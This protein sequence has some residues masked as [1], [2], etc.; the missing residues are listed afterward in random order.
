[1]AYGSTE[2]NYFKA[3]DNNPQGVPTTTNFSVT[4]EDN[5]QGAR[6]GLITIYADNGKRLVGTI[7]RGEKFIP[8]PNATDPSNEL[9]A[10]FNYFSDN[11]NI[12]EVKNQAI[13]TIQRSLSK[14]DP[15][16]TTPTQRATI[17]RSVVFG[18]QPGA[19]PDGTVVSPASSGGGNGGGDGAS[20]DETI[21]LN[22]LKIE[23][24]FPDSENQNKWWYGKDPFVYPDKIDKNNQDFIKFE[25]FEYITKKGSEENPLL[26]AER[27][28]KDKKATI[29]LPI[30]PTITDNNVVDWTSNNLNPV[31][32]GL[33]GIASAGMKADG[34]LTEILGSMGNTVTQD[35]NVGKALLLYLKQKAIGTTGLVSRFGG[36]V[37]NPNM[38]LLFQ[39]PQ[40]RPFNFSFRL[41][42]R[43]DEEAKKVKN[44]IRIFKESMSVR[45]S[46]QGLFLAAPHIFGIKYINGSTKKDHTSLNRIKTCALQSCSVDY[47]PDGSYMTFNDPTTGFPMTSYN[48]TLQFQELEPVTEK[49]YN[50]L[51]DINAIGY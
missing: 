50:D 20:N 47:T 2:G 31:E 43:D 46:S 39:G 38:E 17:A 11:N 33:Y 48:I 51:N 49:D 4:V 13:K 19:N 6:S 37:V 23:Q 44:I 35:S 24:I 9:K 28:L 15:S 8:N 5:T 29:I 34:Q 14:Q 18:P 26:F 10:E 3:K 41:S 25:I 16:G 1:M 40:L 21:S 32:L 27:Q 36:A 7:P 22:D 45:T 12:T 42:P 30:Q